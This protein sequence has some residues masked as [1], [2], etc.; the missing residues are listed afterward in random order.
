M[1]PF[2]RTLTIIT[3][4]NTALLDRMNMTSWSEMVREE[5]KKWNEDPTY[6]VILPFAVQIQ[7][8]QVD[9]ADVEV[10]P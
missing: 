5:L 6:V 7:Q 3:P 4:H 2:G 8:V 1:T 9:G 10:K